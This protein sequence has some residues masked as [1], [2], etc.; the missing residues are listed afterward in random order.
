MPRHKLNATQRR[1]VADRLREFVNDELRIPISELSTKM[2]YA[3]PDTLRSA[4]N[5]R[6]YLSPPMLIALWNVSR[7]HGAAINLHWLLTGEGNPVA[8]AGIAATCS[9][10]SI[11]TRIDT[12]SRAHRQAILQ[13]TNG[14]SARSNH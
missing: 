12:L 2:G 5:A 6:T 14:L 13:I 11:M 4:V 1:E 7:E 8:S 9:A 10:E 3:T